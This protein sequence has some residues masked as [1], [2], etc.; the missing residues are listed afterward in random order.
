MPSSGKAELEPEEQQAG[1]I[2]REHGGEMGAHHAWW[3]PAAAMVLV[4]GRLC[5]KF[6]AQC[7]MQ[8][9]GLCAASVRSVNL[10]FC[11][12]SVSAPCLGWLKEKRQEHVPGR[13]QWL[14]APC[15]TG[16]MGH[17]P[18]SNSGKELPCSKCLCPLGTPRGTHRAH[19][20]SIP[21]PLRSA[22]DT[23]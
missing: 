4:V 5:K 21:A 8:L 20:C 9:F 3:S 18:V 17:N 6:H 14:P 7:W 1:F 11:L 23:C 22:L 2:H 12:C 19:P 10:I 13:G 15:L 16:G